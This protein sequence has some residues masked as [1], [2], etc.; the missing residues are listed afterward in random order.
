[1]ACVYFMSRLI[2]KKS[3]KND[4]NNTRTHNSQPYLMPYTQSTQRL[5]LIAVVVVT[6][7]YDADVYL[8]SSIK[9]VSE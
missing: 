2:E 9:I 6:A 1:M 8:V 4:G 5:P 3:A 7:A